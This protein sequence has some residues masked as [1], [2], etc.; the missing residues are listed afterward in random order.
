MRPYS[1]PLHLH[2]IFILPFR[3]CRCKINIVAIIQL[4]TKNRSEKNLILSSDFIG[5]DIFGELNYKKIMQNGIQTSIVSYGWF[6][7]M[8]YYG[9]IEMNE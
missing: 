3:N 2:I 7:I 1:I 4:K 8:H 6:V 9:I 5:V